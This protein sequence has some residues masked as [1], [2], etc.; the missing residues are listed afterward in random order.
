MNTLSMDRTR[1]T[2]GGVGRKKSD[3]LKSV[4]RALARDIEASSP[5]VRERLATEEG[6]RVVRRPNPQ[7]DDEMAS[8]YYGTVLQRARERTGVRG[9][10]V[11]PIEDGDTHVQLQVSVPRGLYERARKRHGPVAAWL[12]RLAAAM[13][14]EDPDA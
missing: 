12:L 11:R 6:I 9:F 8:G 2:V 5:E 1:E 3:S 10:R 14:P 13:A 7:R 4:E